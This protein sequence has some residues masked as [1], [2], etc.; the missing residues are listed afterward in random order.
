[1]LRRSAAP[2][3][4]N[5]ELDGAR[6]DFAAKRAW[7]GHVEVPLTAREWALLELLIA[8]QGRVVTRLE[9]LDALWGAES[10]AAAASLE[11]IVGRIRKKLGPRLVRTIRGEGYAIS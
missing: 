6:L 5:V 7:A 4:V 3:R 10:A 8:R 1:M 9:I 2:P 11:V